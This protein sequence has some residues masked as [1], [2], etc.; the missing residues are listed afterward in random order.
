MRASHHLLY[1]PGSTSPQYRFPICVIGRDSH[2]DSRTGVFSLPAL[3]N[4]AFRDLC[5]F[6]SLVLTTYFDQSQYRGPWL[7]QD[8]T[9]PLEHL[10]R[11]S[12]R[13]LTMEQ[14]LALTF[15]MVDCLF[16]GIGMATYPTRLPTG[17]QALHA[18]GF[19]CLL[20][21]MY[22]DH[23][24]SVRPSSIITA[25]L[26]V[27][28]GIDALALVYHRYQE[29]RLLHCVLALLLLLAESHNKSSCLQC[30]DSSMAPYAL[31][32]TLDRLFFVWINPILWQGSRKSQIKVP[33]LTPEL[34]PALIKKAALR[35]CLKN[36]ET[37]SRTPP[38]TKSD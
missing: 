17:V 6:T 19:F 28:T 12:I 15:G 26:S 23:R 14:S 8:C 38:R 5:L 37:R 25:Y 2:A 34:S 33:C 36:G 16:V 29:L 24:R 1:L 20:L 35:V 18:L 11:R 32:G 27:V 21:L 30:T 7:P 22:M 10:R 9:V 13:K 4:S 31:A 3:G